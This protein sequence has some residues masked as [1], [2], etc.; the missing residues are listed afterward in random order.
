MAQ[1]PVGRPICGP[2]QSSLA[3]VVNPL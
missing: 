2:Y 1:A 3:T